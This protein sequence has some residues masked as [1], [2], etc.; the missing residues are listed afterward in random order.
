MRSP[1]FFLA[2]IWLGFSASANAEDNARLQIGGATI[3]VTMD[4]APSADFRKLVLDWIATDPSAGVVNLD[5][6]TYA[7]NPANLATWMP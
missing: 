2:L 1:F 3:D 4:P 7:G 5:L 6:L